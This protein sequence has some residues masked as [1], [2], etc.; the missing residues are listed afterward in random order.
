MTIDLIERR[1]ALSSVTCFWCRHRHLDADET[2]DA[3]PRGIPDAIWNGEHDHRSP[4]PGDHGIQ[5]ERMTEEEEAAF[6]AGIDRWRAEFAD[7][8]R[9]F[10]R[11]QA[12]RE[13]ADLADVSS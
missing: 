9:Q 6:R 2:C 10:Q 12:L 4:Y 11:R 7:R 3:F 13:A 8:V 5:F 1:R